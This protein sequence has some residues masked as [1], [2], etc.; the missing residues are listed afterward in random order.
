MLVLKG[1]LFSHLTS[2][3]KHIKEFIT[4]WV[5]L[6]GG[7]TIIS[8][9]GPSNIVRP[10]LE[11]IEPFENPIDPE[12]QV[13]STSSL[14]PSDA[15]LAKSREAYALLVDELPLYDGKP[16]SGPTSKT[17]YEA[18]FVTRLERTGNFRQLTNNYKRA[19]PDSCSSPNHDLILS[20]YKVEPM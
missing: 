5:L 6:I 17:C 15:N 18:D 14:Q 3:M 1:P 20:L 19:V 4:L 11:R 2:E 9:M 13:S 10:R 8:L 12:G 7:L 16:V